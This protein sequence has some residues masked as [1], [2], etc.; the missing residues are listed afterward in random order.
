MNYYRQPYTKPHTGHFRFLNNKVVFHRGSKQSSID[1]EIEWAK[2]FKK[3]NNFMSHK[4][5]KIH[6]TFTSNDE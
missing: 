2:P 1:T 3:E 6:R 4:I 5:T